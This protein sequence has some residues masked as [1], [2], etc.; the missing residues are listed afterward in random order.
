[1]FLR[2]KCIFP[3][4]EDNFFKETSAEKALEY[5]KSKN[6]CP[7]NKFKIGNETDH[8]I[9]EE[10]ESNNKKISPSTTDEQPSE[11]KSKFTDEELID[12]FVQNYAFEVN[13]TKHVRLQDLRNHKTLVP[14]NIGQ[15]YSFVIGN[16]Q[17][18]ALLTNIEFKQK[19]FFSV[20]VDVYLNDDQLFKPDVYFYN[21]PI[22]FERALRFP[23][24]KDTISNNVAFWSTLTESNLG[25][26]HSDVEFLRMVL[27]NTQSNHSKECRLNIRKTRRKYKDL[28][29]KLDTVKSRKQ[30]L[31][32]TIRMEKQKNEDRVVI[33]GIQ[34]NLPMRP[35]LQLEIG[36]EIRTQYKSNPNQS[37]TVVEITEKNMIVEYSLKTGGVKYRLSVPFTKYKE[38]FWM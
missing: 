25:T 27:K 22:I 36:D 32:P 4:T 1:M 33:Y 13:D 37:M 19:V 34:K 29:S 7:N 18:L 24:H 21:P 9:K 38:P 8:E 10:W 31:F 16:R 23:L 30:M 2:R 11:A 28:F 17:Y 15:V 12:D 26:H 14:L 20:T 3:R 5:Y 6:K 35:L